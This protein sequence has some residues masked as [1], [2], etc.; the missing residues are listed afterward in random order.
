MN[1]Q[2]RPSRFPCASAAAVALGC[3]PLLDLALQVALSATDIPAYLPACIPFRDVYACTLVCRVR[4]SCL[5]KNAGGQV[6]FPS[7]YRDSREWHALVPVRL[8]DTRLPGQGN[9][10]PTKAKRPRAEPAPF[11][12]KHIHLLRSMRGMLKLKRA[13]SCIRTIQFTKDIG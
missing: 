2:P 6:G 7:L 4:L 12:T 3:P 13:S 11:V 10:S 8:L 5:R 1:P 9:V